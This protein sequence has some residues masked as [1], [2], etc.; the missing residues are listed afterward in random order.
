MSNQTIKANK[1]K[2]LEI[3]VNGKTY[4]RLPIKTD[5]ITDK[6]D[7]L[8]TLEKYLR[9]HLLPNDIIFISEKVLAITQGRIIN[10]NDIKPS[11]LARFLARKVNNNYGTKDFKGFGHGTPMAMQLFIEEAGYP[12]VIF[13]AAVSAITRPLGIKGLFYLI[14]GKRAKSIDCPLSFNIL[15]Y[16]HHAKLAP[17]DPDGAAK[18]VKE[19]F[20]N[21]TVILDANYL[22]AFSMGKSS[23]KI[24]EKFIQE[25]FRDNPLGQADEMTPFCLLREK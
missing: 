16:A 12:R 14:C 23:N 22:G 21:E 9:P 7:I 24:K 20:G 11:R 25:V 6:N 3:E 5:L 2:N 17:L 10:M 4:L 1:G 18:K 15:E 8:E 13:A 19:K